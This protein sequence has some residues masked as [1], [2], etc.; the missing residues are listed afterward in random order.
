MMKSKSGKIAS[1]GVMTGLALIFSYV[2]FL[3]PVSAAVPGIKLGLANII[4]VIALYVYGTGYAF[5]LNIARILLSALLFGNVFSALYSLAGGLV[6][7]A[8]MALLKKCSIFSVAGVSMAGGVFHNAG[9]IALAALIMQTSQ[10]FYYLPVLI[11]SGIALG[12]VNSIICT[13][14]LRT[15]KKGVLS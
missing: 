10:V 6:S 2:E 8:V 1:M 11:F 15:V 5:M 3:I 7:L 9:Q 12:L 4:V 14:V 13:L